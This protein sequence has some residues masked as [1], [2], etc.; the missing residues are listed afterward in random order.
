MSKVYIRKADDPALFLE[1]VFVEEDEDVPVWNSLEN[2]W[3]LGPEDF[4]EDVADEHGGV[5][6]KI[7]DLRGGS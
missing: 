1:D 6:V 5:V 4:P 2:A 7:T 3:A